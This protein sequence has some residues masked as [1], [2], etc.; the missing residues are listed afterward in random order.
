MKSPLRTALLSTSAVVAM[1]FVTAGTALAD[2][3]PTP[4][5]WPS[6]SPSGY[7]STVPSTGPSTG[8]SAG[9]PSTGPSTGPTSQPSTSSTP[10]PSGSPDPRPSTGAVTGTLRFGDGAPVANAS[11]TVQE[12][13]ANN[14]KVTSTDGN[15]HYSVGDLKPADYTVVFS[16]PG[17]TLT[18]SVP[19]RP[20]AYDG[21]RY[22]VKGGQTTVVND[23]ALPYGTITGHFTDRSGKPVVGAE[24]HAHDDVANIYAWGGSTDPAGVYS[25]WAF[26]GTYAVEFRTSS[27]VRQYAHQKI[28]ES[29]ADKVKVDGGATVVVDEITLPAGTVSG[30]LLDNDGSPAEGA[31]V[32]L[33][34][35]GNSQ[36]LSTRTAGDGTYRFDSVPV[37]DYTVGFTTADYK[38]RQWAFGTTD[39][40]RAATVTVKLDQSLTVDD[41][42]VPTGSLVVTATDGGT[43]RPVADFCVYLSNGGTDGN[44]CSGGSGQV[45]MPDIPA[46]DTYE[47]NV[48]VSSDQYLSTTVRPLVVTGGQTTTKSVVIRPA[49]VVETTVVDAGT[50]RPVPN[51]CVGATKVPDA[52][53]GTNGGP[54][55]DEQ[56]K[57]RLGRLEPATYALY[58]RAHDGVHGDQWVGAGGGTGQLSKAK[59]ITATP[60][61]L[62]TVSPILLDAVGTLSGTVTDKRGARVAG[63]CVSTTAVSAW[64]NRS[65]DCPGTSTDAKGNYKITNLGPY[66]WPVQF[67]SAANYAWQWLGGS[68][69]RQGS[70]L[71]KVRSGRTATA[72]AKLSPGT[73]LKGKITTAGGEPADYSVVLVDAA[74]GEDVAPSGGGEPAGSYEIHLAPQT[75]K[76][77]YSSNRYP[78]TPYWYR[79]AADFA[80]ATP[81][82]VGREP[83]TLDL[84]APVS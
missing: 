42:F 15:G 33:S 9:P 64:S 14:W 63:V 37:G 29:T 38:R 4:G 70:K 7:P 36:Y 50:R 8:P 31:T 43:G 76:V 65:G 49:A 58:A 45:T 40:R 67:A 66:R 62:T 41:T 54:C 1:V 2:P 73:V 12:Y 59:K 3:T 55:S 82:R 17:T 77:V 80:H 71:V 25:L 19:G 30:R 48:S 84:V 74:T 78:S 79:D 28:D 53:A 39:E 52:Y 21:G 32:S 20:N 24:I 18:Q 83:V 51:I 35:V 72:D 61:T 47:A 46:G 11:V 81:V 69:T 34:S 23:T 10:R 22:P 27:G 44:A 56:G 6:G 26:A 75:V 68:P 5:P 16:I 13:R 60:G 57:V